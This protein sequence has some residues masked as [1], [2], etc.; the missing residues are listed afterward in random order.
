MEV[1]S[2]G[3]LEFSE[4]SPA[5]RTDDDGHKVLDIVLGQEDTPTES[6]TCQDKLE[7]YFAVRPASQDVQ[8]RI[9]WKEN[10]AS[11]PGLPAFF[12]VR[13]EEKR[14]AWVAKSHDKAS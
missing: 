2:P 1:H 6:V 11:F 7:L 8:P 14:K 5:M 12:G 10:V 3:S 9:W 4:N 13:R